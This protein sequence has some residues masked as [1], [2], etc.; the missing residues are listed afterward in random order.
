MN[1][2]H[3]GLLA[4]LPPLLS[5]EARET[6]EIQMS[7]C[8]RSR[9]HRL[10]WYPVEAEGD[11]CFGLTLR[12]VPEWRFFSI[13]ELEASYR[14]DPVTVDP[15][16]RPGPFRRVSDIQL[17]HLDDLTPFIPSKPALP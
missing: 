16:H 5:T 17:Y 9:W 6:D 7:L 4:G 12:I 11:V 3:R 1:G 13:S 15:A 10:R 14:G 2:F 8:L